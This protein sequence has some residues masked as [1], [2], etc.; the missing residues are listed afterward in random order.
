MTTEPLQCTVVF[1]KTWE[2][3]NTKDEEGNRKFRYIIEE[4]SSRS[5]K[6]LSLI[7]CYDIYAR[8]NEDKRLTVWR[9]T[10]T[11]CK[12]TVLNDTVKHLKR[13]N[14][15]EVGQSFN[16]TESIFSYDTNSTFEIHGTD[17]EEAVHGLTQDVAWLNEPYKISK[18]TFDQI[19]QRTSDFVI[20]DWNP[21]KA[22][23]IEDL[24]KDP[25]TIVIH[26]TFKDNPFCPI[27]QKR[28][29]L[30]YQ[31][32]AQCFIVKEKLLTEYDA[33]VYDLLENPK[34]FDEK[35][36]RELR[37]CRENEEKK[38]ANAFNWD[39]Y[40]L[41]MKAEKPN[42]IFKWE[43]ISD[44]DYRKINSQIYVATDWGAVDPWG[45]VEAKYYD[46]ALYLH[47]RNYLSET[48]LKSRMTLT[49]LAQISGD[50]EGLVKFMFN[51]LG[52][53]KSTIVICDD[54]RPLK[55]MAL[56]RSG[57]GHAYPAIKIKGSLIDGVDLLN[58]IRVYYTASSTNLRYEQENYSR[59]TDRYGAI[60]EEPEDVDNHLM[61]PSRY[62]GLYLQ[63]R[64]I[65]KKT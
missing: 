4:G 28:K 17:D 33:K 31:T 10:K 2:A 48:E 62:I 38:S 16:K 46:G 49:E 53:D 55:I 18:D 9:D 14:R 52:I 22:H 13:T 65:I 11:D 26:S 63:S 56:R 15:Y 24:K 43:E 64:G 25:R 36:I 5:S 29:I 23:W 12:K 59:K 40:G 1:E 20:I 39:V 47:E 7:D 27:E 51:R 41:G 42:R 44:D 60:L 32:V 6:T 35:H 19:D 50:D 3:I 37:R 34:G 21:K 30:S 8:A 61:D 54:N 57:W 58:N 45:I